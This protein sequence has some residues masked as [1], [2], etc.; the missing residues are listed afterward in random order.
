VFYKPYTIL[1]YIYCT[2]LYTYESIYYSLSHIHFHGIAFT[3][4]GKSGA[5]D[6]ATVE[7]E[8]AGED[9]TDMATTQIQQT[10]FL[11]LGPW[12]KSS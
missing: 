1:A 3:T 2:L 7:E 10:L 11:F 5:S 8:E 12:L 9:G 6:M 4:D